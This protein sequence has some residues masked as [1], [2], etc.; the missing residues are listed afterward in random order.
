MKLDV[1]NAFNSIDRKTFIS[2]VA[3]RYP[4]LYFLVDE[5][6]FNPSTLFAGEH[7]IPS[8][9]IQQRDPLG[10]ALFTLAVEKIAKNVSSELNIWYLDNATIGGQTSSVFND[11][12]KKINAFK[13]IDLQINSNK[14]ELFILNHTADM[15]ADTVK[16]FFSILPSVS[17]PPRHSWS[18]LGSPL[19]H[20]AIVP[21]LDS[22]L[23]D[24]H[25][26]CSKLEEV[27][28]HHA[29]TLLRNCFSIRKLVYIL[30]TCPTFVE[31]MVLM[32]FESIIHAALSSIS[33]VFLSDKSWKQVSLS[34]RFVGLGFRSARALSLPCFLS[35][36]YA[37]SSLV[38][39]FLSSF[40]DALAFDDLQAG[41]VSAREL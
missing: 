23:G 14:C 2:E 1:S 7:C 3:F 37:F 31:T 19:T 5:A 24:I 4:F 18:V 39:L 32:E 10:P 15:Y 30:R 28:T 25:R 21:I 20:E 41:N 40:P 29:F 13:E 33:N 27:K 11:A 34:N 8:R 16:Q 17:L 22:K 9:Y 38:R 6:Y 26:L 35:F 12:T 36:S